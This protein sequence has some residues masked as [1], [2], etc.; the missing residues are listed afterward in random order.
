MNFIWDSNP[1]KTPLFM[2]ILE[3]YSSSPLNFYNRMFRK[4]IRITNNRTKNIC[5]NLA[6]KLRSS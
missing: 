4:I 2:G 1:T 5:M 3:R 6:N